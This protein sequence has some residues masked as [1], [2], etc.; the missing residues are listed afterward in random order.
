MAENQK[1]DAL[2]NNLTR[3]MAVSVLS[4]LCETEDLSAVILKMAEAELQ[5]VDADDI[6]VGLFRSLNALDVD[7]LYDNS[8]KTRY[9]YVEP[10]EMAYEMV[11]GTI[12]IFARDIEKYRDLNMK[13][14]EKEVCLGIVRGLLMYEQ[15]GNN[16][17][18]DWVTDGVSDFVDSVIFEYAEHNSTY[19]SADIR[20]EY[21]AFYESDEWEDG[22]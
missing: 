6:A 12:E 21:E 7:E 19:D 4:K 11:E 22:N 2:L 18:K 15:K 14:A 3:S 8:G 10:S 20:N 17:F 1:K 5:Q 9:G 16:E 13:S